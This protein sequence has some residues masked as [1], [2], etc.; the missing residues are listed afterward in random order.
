MK[1]LLVICLLAPALACAELTPTPGVAD[2]R[3]RVVDYTATDVIKLVTFYGVST[4]IGFAEGETITEVAIGDDQAWQVVERRNNLFVKPRASHADTNLTVITDRRIYH[5]VL[6]VDPRPISDSTVWRDRN[7][8]YSLSF[9]YPSDEAAN[10][11]TKAAAEQALF[12]ASS[13]A[14]D[15]KNRLAAAKQQLENGDYWVAGPPEISPTAAK[16]DGRFIYLAF[17]GNRDMPAVYATDAD[18]NESLVNTHIEGNQIVVHK[19][20]RKLTLRKGSAAACIVNRSFDILGGKDN[21]S[22]TVAPDVDRVIRG[23]R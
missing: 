20:A 23:G 13:R 11:A 9:R 21:L 19:L 1:R 7:L 22:G 3:V 4:H 12:E 17:E 6:M 8:V 10:A 18:G 16:D 15:V 14:A 2:P 5:F